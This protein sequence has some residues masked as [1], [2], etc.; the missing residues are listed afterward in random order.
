[1]NECNKTDQDKLKHLLKC[2]IDKSYKAAVLKKTFSLSFLDNFFINNIVELNRSGC[3]FEAFNFDK[4]LKVDYI[5]ILTAIYFNKKLFR[6]FLKVLPSCIETTFKLLCLTEIE[7]L[8]VIRDK[9]DTDILTIN[10]YSYYD[11]NVIQ[12]FKLFKVNRKSNS[13]YYSCDYSEFE[14]SLPPTIRYTVSKHLFKQDDFLLF[15]KTET[16]LA[17]FIFD[18][19]KKILNELPIYY[20]LF[21]DKKVRFVSND[22]KVS[23][24]SLAGVSK[25]FDLTDFYIDEDTDS[26][27]YLNSNL[28]FLFLKNI[29]YLKNTS[30]DIVTPEIIVRK[31]LVDSY[32]NNNI[33]KPLMEILLSH[34]YKC[35]FTQIQTDAWCKFLH[36]IENLPKGQWVSINRIMKYSFMNS[37]DFKLVLNEQLC[38]EK[39][40]RISIPAISNKDFSILVK[41]PFIKAN[42]FIFAAF[43][44]IDIA[45]D[46]AENYDIDDLEKDYLSIF[47]GLKYVRLNDFGAYIFNQNDTFSISGIR[48]KN[49]E[50]Y[51]D[52]NSLIISL[53]GEDPYKDLILQQ[54]GNKI[55]NDKY[56]IDYSSFAGIS[57]SKADITDKIENFKKEI[58]DRL[59]Q[60]WIDFFTK[61]Q[62]KFEPLTEVTGYYIFKVDNNPEFLRLLSNDH[63]LKQL[64]LKVENYHIM[65]KNS[66]LLKLK[67]RL[68]ELDYYI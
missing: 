3:R 8:D 31:L 33:Q 17:Q 36:I 53:I 34:L 10:T 46:F 52:E 45:Y 42:L 57:K 49:A 32:R 56:R 1:M 2:E 39:I 30:L 61:L 13:V 43:G 37:L 27:K 50:I 16:P 18:D 58:T 40:K 15:G 35:S 29:N 65:V 55:T 19:Y 63:I 66:D 67:D 54:I 68:R 12:W 48:E 38:Y 21:H 28:I 60:N 9:I 14:I 44:I 5:E 7:D 26:I 47:D 6:S 24:S 64:I 25:K 20:K 4:L 62:S 51:L 41:K 59:P 11:V 23:K 22:K